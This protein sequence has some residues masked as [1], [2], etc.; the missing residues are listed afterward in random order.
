MAKINLAR[1]DVPALLKLRDEI[2]A[3][4]S[5]KADE[6]KSQLARLGADGVGKGR[7]G[8]VSA[9]KGRRV[10][11]KYRDPAEVAYQLLTCARRVFVGDRLDVGLPAETVDALRAVALVMP[12]AAVEHERFRSIA[13]PDVAPDPVVELPQRDVIFGVVKADRQPVAIR[14][15]VEEDAGLAVIQNPIGEDRVAPDETV[16]ESRDQGPA[17]GHREVRGGKRFA[18]DER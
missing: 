6:L 3:V 12:G 16:H 13:E 4:L 14:F 15:D 5:Q 8:A 7:R 2:G 10:A 11:A 18:R 9:L 17:K 1:L